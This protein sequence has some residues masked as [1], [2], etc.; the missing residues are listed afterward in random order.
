MTFSPKEN[1][2]RLLLC[3]AASSWWL[4]SYLIGAVCLFSL[5]FQLS[6]LDLGF[7]MNSKE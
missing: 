5:Q 1:A 7:K 3:L 2:E 6:V 4:A